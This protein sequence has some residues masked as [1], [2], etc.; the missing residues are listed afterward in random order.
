MIRTLL[1]T[2]QLAYLNP[3]PTE[4]MGQRLPMAPAIALGALAAPLLFAA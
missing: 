3:K 1:R 2:G 4:V